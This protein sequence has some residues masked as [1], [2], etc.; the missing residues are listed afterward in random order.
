MWQEVEEVRSVS[1]PRVAA[2]AAAVAA[3]PA[4][5]PKTTTTFSRPAFLGG[6]AKAAA[7]TIDMGGDLSEQC[8]DTIKNGDLNN[9]V[10]VMSSVCMSLNVVY[11][12]IGTDMGGSCFIDAAAQVKLLDA[13]VPANFVDRQGQSLLHLVWGTW[14]VRDGWGVVM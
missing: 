6:G 3:S 12:S 11:V 10:R 14:G 13:G 1:P 9:T 2:A 7:S 4:S 5:K 8:R